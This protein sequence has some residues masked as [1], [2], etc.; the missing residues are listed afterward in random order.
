MK[1]LGKLTLKELECNI[2]VIPHAILEKIKGGDGI[3]TVTFD[4]SDGMIYVYENG[5]L[6]SSYPASNIA[7]SS[8]N[9]NWPD[10]TYTILDQ[11][12]ANAIGG[13]SSSS[14]GP[15]GIY[16][17]N[18]F[19]DGWCQ[20]TAMGLHAGRD[21][22]YL[23]PTDG[24]IRSTEEAMNEIACLIGSDGRFVSITIQH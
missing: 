10:G 22:D 24:C 4:R 23:H 20:R 11:H 7:Q 9:G 5:R 14:I 21:N 3:V 13:S 12:Y 15:G 2:P 19:M 18:N 6:M 1:R 17:A 16:R 8:S